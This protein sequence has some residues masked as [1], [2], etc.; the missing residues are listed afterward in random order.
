MQST[1]IYSKSRKPESQTPDPAAITRVLMAAAGVPF[2]ML[3]KVLPFILIGIGVDDMVK[4]RGCDTCAIDNT[5]VAL[6]SLGNF[7]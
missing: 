3:A 1:F 2:T 4:Y 6:F 7:A 5:C